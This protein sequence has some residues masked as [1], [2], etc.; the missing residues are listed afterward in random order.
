MNEIYKITD[1]DHFGRG[2]INVNGKIGFVNN[3]F[4]GDEVTIEILE[5]KKDF[6]VCNVKEY[7][8][9]SKLRKASYCKYCNACGGCDIGELKYEEQL[10]YKKLRIRNILDKYLKESIKINDI[11]YSNDL[12][13]RNKI[14]LH[15]ENG[16]LGLFEKNSNVLVPIDFCLLVNPKINEIIS[17]L[18]K[19]VKNKK[20]DSIVIKCS[21]LD[22]VMLVFYGN[23]DA[24][25]VLNTFSCE[26]IFIN[27]KCIKCKYI[28]EKLGNYKFALSKDSFFQVNRFNTINLYNEVV[29]FI[30]KGSY[31]SALDLY[32]GTGTIGIFVSKYVGNIIGIE[33]VSDAI[34]SAN[35]N[36]KI[37][38]IKNIE[39]VCGKVENFINKI[40]SVDLVITDPPRKGMDKKTVNEILKLNPNSIIYISCNIMT[41]VRDLN[42]LKNK[43]KI[44]ELTPVDMFP[45]T[46]HCESI[47]ILERR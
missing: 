33:L 7:K 36:K 6:L 27:D 10:K 1:L 21:N 37:N 43:Y 42:I 11:I 9:K 38:K 32:C 23:V 13:Y 15:V 25:D 29:R 20:I 34:E 14:T 35:V 30:K 19:F 18:K 39:F 44:I 17:E 40:K 22:Q 24:D 12:C 28:Y 4:V 8:S 26:S 45:N 31:K 16:E 41:L 46:Y 47:T 2:I 5:Q 3:A